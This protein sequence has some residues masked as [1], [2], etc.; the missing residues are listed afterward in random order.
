MV[1]RLVLLAAVKVRGR[2]LGELA[3]TGRIKVLPAGMLALG[4]GSITGTAKTGNNR[5]PKS[6]K[7]PEDTSAIHDMIR[8][9]IISHPETARNLPAYLSRFPSCSFRRKRPLSATMRNFPPGA[10]RV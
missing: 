1:M 2:P 6:K 7:T 10:G 4:M 8:D 5:A 9:D 3:V